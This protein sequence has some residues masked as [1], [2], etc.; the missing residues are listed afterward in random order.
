MPTNF[1]IH[2]IQIQDN[3]HTGATTHHYQYAYSIDYQEEDKAIL[4]TTPFYFSI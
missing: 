4:E 2:N 1:E 3:N